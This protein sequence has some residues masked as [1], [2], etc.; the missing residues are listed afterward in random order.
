MNQPLLSEREL[1]I[2]RQV[3][4]GA[5]NREIAQ[6]LD[7]SP[8]TVKVHLRNIFD[9]LGVASRTEAT[10]YAIRQGWVL[11]DGQSAEQ[12]ANGVTTPV[13]PLA[14]GEDE[15]L[16][17][18]SPPVAP[19]EPDTV[20]PV[21]I[22]EA[23]LLTLGSTPAAV[24]PAEGA[25]IYTAPAQSETLPSQPR[26]PAWL[27]P[28]LGV[29]IG[30]LLTLVVVLGIQAL[31]PTT[32]TQFVVEEPTRWTPSIELPTA[33]RNVMAAAPGGDLFTVG[34]ITADGA[35]SDEVWQLAQG[36]T[37]W[38]ARAPLPLPVQDATLTFSGGMVYVVGGFDADGEPVATTQRYNTAEDT[39]IDSTLL[40]LPLARGALVAFE[41]TLYYIGGTDG[42]EIQSTIYRLLPIGETWEEVATLPAPRADLAAVAVSDGI[43]L[44]GGVDG[45]QRA[46]NDVLHFSPTGATPFRE[47]NPLPAPDSHPRA[48]TLGSVVYLLGI[49]GF[50]ERGSDQEWRAVGLPETPLPA[51]AA[52]VAADPYI[53]V[54][55][56]QRGDTAVGEVLQY[57]AI[58]RSFIPIVPNQTD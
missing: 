17:E 42:T 54:I 9:K 34:G 22:V 52:L 6:T 45:D 32:P 44:F 49:Q 2:V 27:L 40:P 38:E 37:A 14:L 31:R 57:Q 7:I 50:L 1:D 46:V 55:G 16:L 5:S 21:D 4:T 3:A 36:A 56:G 58:Y 53:L 13:V 24:T 29:V 18:A 11:V 28:V 20:E 43:L 41:G 19:D 12:S 33:R 35:I 30:V 25:A 26:M 23:P 47:E 10:Y 39:W 15:D 48:V 8:N 51:N